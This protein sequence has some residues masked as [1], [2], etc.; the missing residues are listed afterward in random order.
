[1]GDS[2]VKRPFRAIRSGSL[3]HPPIPSVH[4]FPSTADPDLPPDQDPF[5]LISGL[6][7]AA[8]FDQQIVMVEPG[9]Q[10]AVQMHCQSTQFC[11]AVEKEVLED[12]VV[13]DSVTRG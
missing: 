13:K 3:R 12:L 10:S 8:A 6:E 5:S 7:N 1:M 4:A 9:P 11:L 2:S